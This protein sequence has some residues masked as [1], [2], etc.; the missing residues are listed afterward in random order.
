MNRRASF[1]SA[2]VCAGAVSA[3]PP[4]RGRA[5]GSE[6]R[7]EE[8]DPTATRT[9]WD[10]VYTEEQAQ[11]GAKGYLRECASCHRE[12]LGGDQTSPSL[13]GENF[14][15]Q[16][17][18]GSV[19]DLFVQTR[20][21]MPPDGPASLS[22]QTYCDIVAFILKSNKFPSGKEELASEADRLKQILITASRPVPK[23]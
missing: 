14:S 20:T 1:A 7:R 6:G 16:W 2:L 19:N 18:D 11:R 10:G 13:V 3:S 15:F 23:R 9:V 5:D 21:L 22:N 12:D 8:A 17:T 4:L